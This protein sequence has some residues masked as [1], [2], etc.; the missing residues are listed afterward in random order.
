MSFSTTEVMSV[1]YL[2]VRLQRKLP[3]F[4]LDSSRNDDGKYSN[5][6]M[7]IAGGQRLSLEGDFDQHFALHSPRGYERDAL[8]IF[9]PDLMA[10]SSTRPATST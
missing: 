8:Y 9:T 4:V 7:P 10:L 5:L 2:A 1:G 6:P 3:Q